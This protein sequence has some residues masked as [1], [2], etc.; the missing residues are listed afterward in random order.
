MH[1]EASD[2]LHRSM[3]EPDRE[4]LQSGLRPPMLDI[5]PRSGARLALPYTALRQVEFDPDVR[6]PLVITFS[7]HVV[8]VDGRNLESLYLAL[9][10][11]RAQSIIEQNPRHE[12]DG[13]NGVWIE[14][15]RIKKK[16]KQRS[17]AG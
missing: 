3:F 11:H 13:Q 6:P 7:S 5:R 17:Q 15:L 1:R 10:S 16:R 9:V 4:S 8:S 2:F 14:S 12:E